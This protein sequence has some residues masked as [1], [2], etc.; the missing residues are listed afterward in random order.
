MFIL[1]P[2]DQLRRP[3]SGHCDGVPVG[4][5]PSVRPDFFA[6]YDVSRHLKA[7]ILFGRIPGYSHAITRNIEDS[8]TARRSSHI[9]GTRPS[10]LFFLRLQIL[11]S[12]HKKNLSMNLT[13][14]TLAGDNP[15]LQELSGAVAIN[16][17]RPEHVL[18]SLNQLFKLEGGSADRVTNSN[19]TGS[20]SIAL[21]HHIT[22]DGGSSIP[23]WR[24]PAA[25]HRGGVHLIKL[26]G[27]AGFIRFGW[28]Q[29]WR[30]TDHSRH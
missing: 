3:V 18:V 4:T 15:R 27:S 10:S 19:P 8:G 29:I 12:Y 2:L 16:G 22:A 14:Q 9:C 28:K 7:T 6:L 1:Q 26:E 25:G 17:C 13:G 5:H 24:I 20:V 21:L 11:C 30:I 23:N